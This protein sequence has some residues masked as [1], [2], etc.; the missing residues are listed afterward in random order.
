MSIL[1]T[2]RTLKRLDEMLTDA[3]EGRFE[4][5][6]YDETELS[7]LESRWKQYLT[8]SKLSVEAARRERTDIKSILSDISHQTK[9]PLSN[10]I[11]YSELLKEQPLTPG[12]GGDRGPA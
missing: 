7:R 4:E 10:I 9:T 8:T 3:I 1:R 6:K 12:G 2:G 11:L 5:G